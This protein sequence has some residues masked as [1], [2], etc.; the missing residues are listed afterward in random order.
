MLYFLLYTV[1]FAKHT[2]Q[3]NAEDSMGDGEFE[4][5][6]WARQWFTVLS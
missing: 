4:P 1:Y 3:R 5:Q 2:I 6:Q